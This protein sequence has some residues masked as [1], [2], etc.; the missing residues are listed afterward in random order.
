VNGDTITLVNDAMPVAPDV[1]FGADH[2]VP[3]R[4]GEHVGWRLA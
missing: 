3:F 1:P 2:L 4:A